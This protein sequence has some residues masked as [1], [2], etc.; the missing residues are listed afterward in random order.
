GQNDWKAGLT[1][2]YLLMSTPTCGLTLER[3]GSMHLGAFPDSSFT[4]D[5]EDRRSVSGGAVM[6][7]GV[8]VLWF[9]RTQQCVALSRTEA[10]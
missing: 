5:E 2:L 6:F 8:E 9:F 7:P 1:V 3:T 4:G 10:E